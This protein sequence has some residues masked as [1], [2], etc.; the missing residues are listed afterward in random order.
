MLSIFADTPLYPSTYSCE[1]SLLS[2]RQNNFEGTSTHSHTIY[3]KVKRKNLDFYHLLP[4]Y[5]SASI[6]IFRFLKRMAFSH[7]MYISFIFLFRL[8]LP[9]N[10]IKKL[11][12]PKCTFGCMHRFLSYVKFYH[13]RK[14]LTFCHYVYL[15]CAF[16]P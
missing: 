7:F 6:R 13:R 16:D 3:G 5:F 8:L 1:D 4:R 10:F 9:L 15:L 2:Y 12:I 11:E 14:F